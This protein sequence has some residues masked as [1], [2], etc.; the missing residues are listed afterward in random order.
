MD[1]RM[2]DGFYRDLAR[3]VLVIGAVS[4]GL[5]LLARPMLNYAIHHISIHWIK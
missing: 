5:G 3:M 4:F 2:F 1:S